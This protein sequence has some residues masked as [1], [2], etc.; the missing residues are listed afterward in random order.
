MRLLRLALV[1]SALFAVGVAAGCG[2][3][4][5]N[6]SG[7]S[8][9]ASTSSGGTSSASGKTVTIKESEY[10]LT[11]SS[12]TLDTTGTYT[13]KV[14]NTGSVTHALEI[15]G[16]GV[17]EESGDVDAG[18][19]KTFSVDLKSGGTYELYCPIDGHRQE[20]MEGKLTIGNAGAGSAGTTSDTSTTETE[21]HTDTGGG[22]GGY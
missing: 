8:E 11:P 19:T 16:N 15:E 4:S 10:K 5:D 21:T 3:S 6:S 1:A 9:A 18:S 13:F 20:G 14:V 7:Q 2:G 17:E 12:V 22:G